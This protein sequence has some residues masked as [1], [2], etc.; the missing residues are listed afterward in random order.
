MSA[1]VPRYDWNRARNYLSRPSPS[2]IEERQRKYETGWQLSRVRR[3][4]GEQ[5]ASLARYVGGLTQ[6][7]APTGATA[8]FVFARQLDATTRAWRALVPLAILFIA[9]ATVVFRQ[10]VHGPLA[11]AG[12]SLI[13]GAALWGWRAVPASVAD[14]NLNYVAARHLILALLVGS[15]WALFGLSITAHAGKDL[16]FLVLVVEMALMAVGLIMYVNLPV[17]FVGFSTPIAIALAATSAPITLGGPSV[18]FTLIIVYYCILAKAAVDQS[19]VFEEA[20]TA[21]GRL[22]E[23]EAARL[24]IERDAAEAQVRSAAEARTRDAEQRMAAAR[25]AEQLKRASLLDLGERF[26][27]QVAA[28]VTL[29][30]EAVAELDQ[31]AAKLAVVGQSSAGAAADVAQRATDAAASAMIVA[32][33]ADELGASVREISSQVDG[34]ADLS[35]A[36]RQLASSSAEKVYA[37]C[38]DAARIDTVIELVEGVAS[39]TRLLALNATIEAS[40]AGEVGKGFA[41]VAGE[42]KAL[43]NR[44]TAATIDVRDQTGAIV[45]QI[46]AV[47]ARM[48][49][50][51]QKIDAVADIASF[52]A[53]SIAQQR[54]AT[55][56]IGRE[57][58]LV[59]DHIDDV[60]GRAAELAAGAQATDQLARAM[61]ETV[62]GLSRQALALRAS[63][64]SFLQELRA[65]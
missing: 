41:V 38:D 23:S 46:G 21:V 14:D 17:G 26:E 39:Q 51:A 31:A 7:R 65:T 4:T 45:D 11:A 24:Q 58:N 36:A 33:A 37:I 18:S 34:H 10:S 22:A 44:T 30:S 52:V 53:A 59:A 40:R 9:V 32:T 49:D 8:R 47:S 62:I 42:I 35:K 5:Y 27:R 25:E 50:T 48:A 57:T 16:S 63:S 43:A 19:T 29:L 1:S 61:N 3:F 6:L 12:A 54:Q 64:A 15:G 28:A 56:E 60:R 20:Q 55:M 2:K 13:I